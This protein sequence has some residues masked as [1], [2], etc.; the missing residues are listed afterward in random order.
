MSTTMFFEQK[1]YPA[2]D[3]GRADK[4]QNSTNIEL[5][6]TNYFGDDQIFLRVDTSNG[7]RNT[8]H[9]TKEQALELAEALTSVV[10]C[11]GYE[12]R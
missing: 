11:I 5:F 2:N 9:L 6:R 1:L 8:V 3:E 4:S 12:N 7:E 10:S